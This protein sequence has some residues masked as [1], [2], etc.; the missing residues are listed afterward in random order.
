M[1]NILVYSLL[2]FDVLLHVLIVC[3]LFWICPVDVPL[4]KYINELLH[5]QK[6]DMLGNG[7]S[8]LSV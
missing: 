3:I 1:L 6:P 5:A 8:F 4:Q 7:L 2:F